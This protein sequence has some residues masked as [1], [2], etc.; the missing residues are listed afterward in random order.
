MNFGLNVG[1]AQYRVDVLFD[2]IGLALL[3]QQDAALTGAKALELVIYQRIG[4]VEH[5]QWH[6]RLAESIG[7]TEHFEP[8]QH[9]VVKPA[10]HHDA[11]VFGA[12]GKKLIDLM[13]LNEFDSCR[14][15]LVDLFEL[16][17]VAGRWQHH[18]AGVAPRVFDRV[19][20]R[21]CGA[22]VGLGGEAAVDMTGAN[23]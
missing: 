14:P 21:E 1:L 11:K 10:L 17:R 8:T 6:F 15:A 3:N 12:F 13:V 5:I 2:E 20:Q 16:L 18:A 23:A 22:F 9:A 19:F 7:E 4:D